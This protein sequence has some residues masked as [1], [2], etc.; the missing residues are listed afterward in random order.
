MVILV[1]AG[2]VACRSRPPADAGSAAASALASPA[3]A[4]SAPVGPS[5]PVADGALPPAANEIAP[6]RLR[7]PAIAVDARV[8][9]VSID[10]ATNDFAVPPS[11]DIVGWYRHG[12]GLAATAGSVVIA[13]HVDGAGQGP[14]AFFR[15]RDLAMGAVIEV[16]GADGRLVRYAVVARETY[17][18]SAIPLDRYFARDGSPRLTLITCGGP[19]DRTTR[20]Y[21]DNVVVTAVAQ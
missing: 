11:I 4:S 15:L 2:T 12:P 3:P 9:P 19:F 10:A 20:S 21:R 1:G 17:D 7:I 5:V 6:V 18:K 8:D 16:R 13:G 14:G